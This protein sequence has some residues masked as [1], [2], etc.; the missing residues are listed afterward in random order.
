M[1]RKLTTELVRTEVRRFWQ[2]FAQYDVRT[3]NSMYGHDAAV[4]HPSSKRFELGPLTAARYER[5]YAR[6]DCKFTFQ[7]GEIH[8]VLL[9]ENIAVATYTFELHISNVTTPAGLIDRHVSPGRASQVFACDSEGNIKIVHE[10]RSTAA[11]PGGPAAS[12]VQKPFPLTQQPFSA[13]E[14]HI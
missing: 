10:H 1:N 9:A 8:V 2:A 4:F 6:P 7:L 11:K 3:I 13:Q 5:E 12:A 14:R